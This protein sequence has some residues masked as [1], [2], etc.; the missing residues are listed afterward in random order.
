MKVTYWEF[1]FAF[2]KLKTGQFIK[3]WHIYSIIVFFKENLYYIW[4]GITHVILHI[5]HLTEISDIG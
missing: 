2:W 3:N 4:K 5:C 1:H